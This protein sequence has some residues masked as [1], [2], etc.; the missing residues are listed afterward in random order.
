MRLPSK[1]IK[2][3]FCAFLSIIMLSTFMQTEALAKRVGSGK[4]IGRQN[5]QATRNYTPPPAQPN[6]APQNPQ[7]AWQQPGSVNN[8]ATA[9]QAAAPKSKW[10]GMGSILGG[11]AAGLGLAW[12]ASHFGLG[13]ELS[14]IL[15]AILIGF[16][17]LALV[18]WLMRKKAAPVQNMGYAAYSGTSPQSHLQQ[19]LAG[20]VP[21]QMP[22][23]A[24]ALS[25]TL[26]A[27]KPLAQA[28]EAVQQLCQK[29]AFWFESVQRFSDDKNF[30]A[31][32]KHLSPEL[33]TVIQADLQGSVAN[34]TIVQ[35]IHTDLVDWQDNGAEYLVTMSYQA[36]VSEDNQAFERVSEAWTFTKPVHGNADWQLAGITQLPS[37]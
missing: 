4:S 16:L 21:G 34:K 28:P 35:N 24:P 8:A 20:A 6:Q 23:A 5:T 9:A 7:G 25:A 17:V 19:T 2:Q 12:L 33:F 36:M 11:V 27:V 14:G 37:A 31:L 29:A 32:A 10:G 26:P 1:P 22:S 3:L 18:R 30:D 13:S 15:G